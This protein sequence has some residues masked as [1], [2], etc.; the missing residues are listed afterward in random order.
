MVWLFLVVIVTIN[1]RHHRHLVLVYV[2]YI[3]CSSVSTVDSMLYWE[4]KR[5]I[6]MAGKGS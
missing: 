6:K 4:R 5:N 3:V 1:I 2:V